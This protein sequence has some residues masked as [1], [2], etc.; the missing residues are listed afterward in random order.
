M[1]TQRRCAGSDDIRGWK[2]EQRRFLGRLS[3]SAKPRRQEQQTLI[4]GVEG[5][6]QY[7]HRRN[8]LLQEGFQRREITEIDGNAH[9]LRG[10]AGERE[11]KRIRHSRHMDGIDG[12]Q[13]RCMQRS[14][15]L[16]RKIG[17]PPPSLAFFAGCLQC[18]RPTSWHADD[19]QYW[20]HCF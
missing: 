4:D 9:V 10:D 6:V 2:T 13:P 1:T 11:R 8:V 5:I 17:Q 19:V 18:R 20:S 3:S 7:D 16:R 14:A 12:Q 15:Q